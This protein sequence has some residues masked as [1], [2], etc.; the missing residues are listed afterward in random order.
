MLHKRNNTETGLGKSAP[1]FRK[2]W[3]GYSTG[4]QHLKPV[5]AQATPLHFHVVKLQHLDTGPIQ[6]TRGVFLAVII[7]SLPYVSNKQPCLQDNLSF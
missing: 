6:C 3:A 5:K 4:Q 7:V 2:R 1:P